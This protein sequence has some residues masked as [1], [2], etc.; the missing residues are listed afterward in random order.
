MDDNL[1]GIR[2]VEASGSHGWDECAL[3]PQSGAGLCTRAEGTAP[4]GVPISPVEPYVRHFVEFRRT[5]PDGGVNVVPVT[6][7][8]PLS[9]VA[10]LV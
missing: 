6:E 7:A 5:L 1:L 8:S 2:T 9:P 4:A 10:Y 3:V